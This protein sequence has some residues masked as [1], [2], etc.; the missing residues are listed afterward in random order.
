MCLAEKGIDAFPSDKIEGDVAVCWECAFPLMLGRAVME[1]VGLEKQKWLR[2]L[3]ELEGEVTLTYPDEGIWEC[4]L[5]KV[6]VPMKTKTLPHKPDC[7]LYRD[8]DG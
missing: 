6:R 1:A 3:H 2:K 5:C 7:A 4:P 8:D